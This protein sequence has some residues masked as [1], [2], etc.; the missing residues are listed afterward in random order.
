MWSTIRRAARARRLPWRAR[1]S[2]RVARIFT[3]ANSAATKKPFRRTRKRARTRA[4]V[5]HI[6]WGAASWPAPDQDGITLQPRAEGRRRPHPPI[7][8]D[9][10][11]GGHLRG[12]KALTRGDPLVTLRP[13][14]H[15]DIVIDGAYGEGGGQ[16]LRTALSLSAL[17]TR[18]VRIENIRAG[19]RNP[20]LQAQHLVALQALGEIT[21][22]EVEGA[23]VGA[24][25]VRFAPGPVRP[26][27]YRF[28]VG[29]A[30]A[31]ALVPQAVPLPLAWGGAVSDLT[32]TGGTH[33]P[34]SPPV[35][36][37]EEVLLPTLAP[38]GVH[39]S[40]ELHRWGFYPKGGGEV[41]VAVRPSSGTLR[42]L[43]RLTRGM[44]RAVRGTAVVVR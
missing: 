33:V 41:R 14:P 10:R 27:S 24:T 36:Y 42:P 11:S 18:P 8:G 17:L 16:I 13:N 29:T 31:G 26:G 25:V 6:R 44:L 40:V 9:C 23:R 4:M 5:F 21:R 37:L 3:I 43:T 34:W 35:P 19:R 30:G 32:V 12:G 2:S 38:V 28:A 22:G 15:M 7:R 20:G 39:A 1:S